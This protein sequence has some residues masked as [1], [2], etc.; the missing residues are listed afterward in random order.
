MAVKLQL[1]KK[2]QGYDRLVTLTVLVYMHLWILEGAI[3]KWVPG[4]EQLMYVARDA[5][6]VGAVV[7]LG[8]GSAR[9]TRSA[10][11]F[12]AATLSLAVLVSIQVMYGR[13]SLPIA[14][15]GFRSYV[16]P[17]LLAYVAWCY[18][19]NGMWQRMMKI[20]AAYAPIQAIV[21]IA[22]VMSPARS[23]INKQVGSDAAYFVND[24]IVRASGTYSAPS[25]LSLYVPLALAASFYLI[26]RSPKKMRWFWAL[27]LTSVFVTSLVSGSRGTILAAAIV[28]AA[29]FLLHLSRISRGGFGNVLFTT[30]VG[31]ACFFAILSWLPGV[32]DSFLNRFENASR[33]E[34]ASDRLVGQTFDF[35]ATPFTFIGD[36]AGAHSVAGI[37]LG[38]MGPW[39]E[40]ESVKWV[41]ELGLAGWILAC[42]R[43]LIC[44]VLATLLLSRLSERNIASTVTAAA[45]IPVVL[46]GQITH[47]PSAQGFLSICLTLLILIHRFDP[48]EATYITPMPVAGNSVTRQHRQTELAP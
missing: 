4:S 27:A 5:L 20:I 29:F 17:L 28:F 39:L 24:N 8:L 16:A 36:G 9:R 10:P 30:V 6:V 2:S 35:F 31:V 33:S 22:Q 11:I 19:V 15:V 32:A 42:T 40:I 23:A 43:M 7:M 37:N 41:A 1:G 12:W 45:M 34:N 3:R 18:P 14:A 44:L 46:Y 47:F 48:K 13:I 21:T 38:S 25:G 26:Y